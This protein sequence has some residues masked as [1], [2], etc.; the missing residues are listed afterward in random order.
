MIGAI[1]VVF[2]REVMRMALGLG[3][4]LL[5]VGRVVCAVWIRFP[6]SG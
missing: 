5:A 6:G 1:A 3:A 4:F 2:S